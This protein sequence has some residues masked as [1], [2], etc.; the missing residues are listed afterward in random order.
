MSVLE[1]IL[2]VFTSVGTWIASAF[3]TLEPVFWTAGVEGASGSL[4]FMG[5]LAVAGLAMSVAFLILGVIQ[6]F[7][8]FGA[9]R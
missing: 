6:R 8:K 7:L 5:V 3:S 9:G 1:A 4:T 2:D